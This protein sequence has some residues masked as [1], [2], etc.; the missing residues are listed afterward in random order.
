MPA[1][2]GFSQGSAPESVK[3]PWAEERDLVILLKVAQMSAS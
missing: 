2:K 3:V 1:Q